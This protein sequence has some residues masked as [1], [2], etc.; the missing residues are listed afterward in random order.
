[1]RALLLSAGIGSRLRPITD[2]IPKCLV[3]VSNQTM[4]E[5]WLCKL[6][7]P[8]I[9]E[10]VVNTHHFSELVLAEIDKLNQREFITPIF[11]P[12][13]LGTAGTLLANI[14][15]QDE[16]L[17][18][19]HCDNFSSIDITSFIDFHKENNNFLTIGVFKPADPTACG[20]VSI[21]ATGTINQFIEKPAKSELQWGNAAVYLFSKA[22]LM[23]I[24]SNYIEA[25][26]IARDILPIFTKRMSAF[27]IKGYHIDIGTINGLK[28]A[29]DAHA[30]E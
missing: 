12:E 10:V 1:V 7:T 4:L 3:K 16:S 6:N 27:E 11:E 9:S 26:D 30:N 24:K 2:S 29:Q 8:E 14:N 21:S 23:E 18:V 15:V 17:L 5:H 13:L 25:F 19:A 20:M 28:N 22:A